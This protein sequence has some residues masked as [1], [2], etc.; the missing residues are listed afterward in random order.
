MSSDSGRAAD[1][2]SDETLLHLN[3]STLLRQTVRTIAH[4]LNNI[5][6]LVAGSAELMGTNPSFP[7]PLR[8]KLSMIATQSARGTELVDEIVT[9]AREDLPRGS[10]VDVGRA[11][12]RVIGLRHFEH[13]RAGI[14]AKVDLPQTTVVAR[15][16]P[17]DTFVMLLNLIVNAEQAMEGVESRTLEIEVSR[18]GRECRVTIA[19]SGA[20]APANLDLFAPLTT[21][22][23]LAAAAGLGL[24]AT[25]VLAQRYGGRVEI[26]P[27]HTGFA[28]ALSLPAAGDQAFT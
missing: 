7:E 6:Q 16:D 19:D 9:L 17:I 8:R 28:I 2:A 24:P 21:T 3:R 13:T 11:V 18:A 26:S 4:E 5:F 15:A 12:T 20:G 14:D 10:I 25:R 23:P 1:L 22:K 27:R